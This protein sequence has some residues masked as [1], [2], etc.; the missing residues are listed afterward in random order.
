MTIEVLDTT[1]WS[2]V[3]GGTW[4]GSC[5]GMSGQL[6]KCRL[7][8]VVFYVRENMGGVDRFFTS[9]SARL[10]MKKGQMPS[11]STQVLDLCAPAERWEAIAAAVRAEDAKV[12]EPR[13]IRHHLQFTVA[14][15]EE[16]FK[17]GG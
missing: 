11:G 12:G 7:E 1:W 17:P 5:G 15:A 13:Q 4:A 9:S 10:G 14:W 8:G 3:S 16:R 2:V 6:T